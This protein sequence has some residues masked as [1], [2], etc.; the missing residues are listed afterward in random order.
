MLFHHYK[1]TECSIAILILFYHFFL[2]LFNSC[3]SDNWICIWQFVK[4]LWGLTVPQCNM[5]AVQQREFTAVLQLWSF[6]PFEPCTTSTWTWRPREVCETCSAMPMFRSPLTLWQSGGRVVVTDACDA[7]SIQSSVWDCSGLFR[8]C[9]IKPYEPERI[10][11]VYSL[12]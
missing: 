10:H 11:T 9:T 1:I 2:L 4:A 5:A 3:Q 7:G 6:I 12:W 8:Q